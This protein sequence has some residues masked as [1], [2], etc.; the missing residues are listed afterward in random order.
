MIFEHE[1]FETLKSK[2]VE[3]LWNADPFSHFVALDI[4][5]TVLH[6]DTNQTVQGVPEGMFVY[7]I[8]R[9]YGITVVFI[10]AREYDE[11]SEEMARQDLEHVGI[12][13]MESIIMR[14]SWINTWEGI[15]LFK[16]DARAFWED[17]Y[18]MVCLLNVGDQW[19]DMMHM[20]QDVI[21]KL[22]SSSYQYVLFNRTSPNGEIRWNLKL[23]ET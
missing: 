10:T 23:T 22:R 4:D 15:S 2:V 14:P 18:N 5:S 7:K 19:T 12:T 8:A 16:S 11:A 20:N 3:I 17:R 13:D 9:T 21:H 1:Q 6:H